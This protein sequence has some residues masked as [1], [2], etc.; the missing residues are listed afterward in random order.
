VNDV[1]FCPKCGAYWDCGCEYE[2]TAPA[3]IANN[4]CVHDWVDTVAV[5]RG[6]GFDDAL[7]VFVCRLC[8]LYKASFVRPGADEPD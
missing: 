1:D 2:I 6:E 7:D 8:G 3:A 4:G 5:E